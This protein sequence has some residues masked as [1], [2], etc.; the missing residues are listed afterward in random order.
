[1]SQ[2]KEIEVFG[3]V[4][5]LC[6]FFTIIVSTDSIGL[7]RSGLQV[8]AASVLYGQLFFVVIVLNLVIRGSSFNPETGEDENEATEPNLSRKKEDKT[9]SKRWVDGSDSTRPSIGRQQHVVRKTEGTAKTEDNGELS[10]KLVP[11]KLAPGPITWYL[12]A[13]HAM[14]E[15]R[16][17]HSPEVAARAYELGL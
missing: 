4:E 1:L 7:S 3:C 14:T 10:D 8:L 9:S 5:I 13:S 11:E 17:N 6:T 15:H 16:L 2:K 12:Y